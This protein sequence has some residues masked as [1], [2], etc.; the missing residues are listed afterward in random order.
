MGDADGDG[1]ADLVWRDTGT[2]LVA[3]WYMA[4]ET[5]AGDRS[6]VLASNLP[7]NWIIAGIGDLDNNGTADVVW[8]NTT[9]GD[10]AGWLMTGLVLDTPAVILNGL[11]LEWE[12]Q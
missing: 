6:A 2:G 10:V 5:G 12:L 3:A 7:F 1:N 11:S 8:R 4:A 9:T